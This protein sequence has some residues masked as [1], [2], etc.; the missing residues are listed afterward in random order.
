MENE[1]IVEILDAIIER[2]RYTGNINQNVTPEEV[3]NTQLNQSPIINEIDISSRDNNDESQSV[4]LNHMLEGDNRDNTIRL[5]LRNVAY[6][7]T[8]QD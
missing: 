8:L 2:F 1:N 6:A 7:V 5:I 4:E 3:I